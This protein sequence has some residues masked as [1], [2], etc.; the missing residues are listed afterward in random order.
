VRTLKAL[1]YLAPE[2]EPVYRAVLDAAGRALGLRITLEA[3][4]DYALAPEAD[5]A[6]ICGLPYVLAS[7]ALEALAAPVL[8][9]ARYADKPIYFSEVVVRHD[10]PAT[11]FDALRGCAWAYN[12]PLSQSGCGIVCTALAQ[13]GET[14][15]FFGRVIQAG[16]HWRALHMVAAGEADGAAIDSQV[17]AVILRDDP[18][19]AQQIRVIDTLG[20]S[21]IQPLAASRR[22]DAAI[23]RDLQATL[24]EL[25]LAEA[26]RALLDRALI[27]RF[28]PMS[29]RDYDDLR[30]MRALC[31]QS[32]V[33]RLD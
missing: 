16:F 25:H 20:P 6:F 33:T 28:M 11:S 21:T 4:E 23:R 12:E 26:G 9:G 13:R 30:A 1:T 31:E 15:A 7:D 27:D 3:A 5:L 29:D 32:G 8:Q 17:L 10:S 22:L 19:L 24:A 14:A 18:G 2:N